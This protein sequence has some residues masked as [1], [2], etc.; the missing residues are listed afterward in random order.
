SVAA[1]AGA[2]CWMLRGWL[3]GR[4]AWLGAMLAAAQLVVLGRE[5]GG[6]VIGYWSQSYW[7]GAVAATGGAL[8]FGALPRLLRGGRFRDSVFF[9][10]GLAVLANSRPYEGLAAILP[11]CGILG[12]AWW[13]RRLPVRLM[14]PI[15]SLIILTAAA[16]GYYNYRVTGQVF[17]MPAVEHYEQYC[18]FPLFLWQP[19]RELPGWTHAILEKFHDGWEMNL[20]TRHFPWPN[21]FKQ[22]A[23]KLGRLWAF[24]LGPVLTLPLLFLPW[25][26]KFWPALGAC[27]L[28]L[29]AC[30]LCVR[31]APHYVAPAAP[32]LFLLIAA[33]FRRLHHLRL[34]GWPLGALLG[35]A[36]FITVWTQALAALPLPQRGNTSVSRFMSYRRDIEQKL[37][38]AGGKHLVLVRYG[39]RHSLQNEW[40]YNAA[41]IDASPVVWARAMSEDENRALLDYFHDRMAWCLEIDD[42]AQ[43]P[44]LHV[45]CSSGAPAPEFLSADRAAE[46]Q[47]EKQPKQLRMTLSAP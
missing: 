3:P 6:G 34:R 17:K 24:F 31:A 36:V 29:A 30:L 27:G 47:P 16:M 43:R 14:L 21:L 41:D 13:R 9:G 4:W 38:R 39:T 18:T 23:L 19:T 25:R 2:F 46:L 35:L 45:S 28:T 42:D 10:L 20:Y 22:T 40:V 44:F 5:Y 33:G 15:A 8:V 37:I 26:S 32:M 1:M 12:W 11:A 7:G